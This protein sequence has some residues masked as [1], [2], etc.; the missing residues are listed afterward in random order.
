MSKAHLE[1]AESMALLGPNT[2]RARDLLDQVTDPELAGRVALCR[3]QVELF[4]GAQDQAVL[5]ALAA[6]EQLEDDPVWG[7][8]A[9]LQCARLLNRTLRRE[10]AAELLRE[11]EQDAAVADPDTR[12][13]WHATRGEVA[14]DDQRDADAHEAFRLARGLALDPHRAHE[15]LQA[16]WML[17]LQAQLRDD[18]PEALTLLSEVHR[19]AAAHDDTKRFG[20]VSVALGNLRFRVHDWRAARRYLEQG[21]A[22]RVDD[23][24]VVQAE[25][26]PPLLGLLARAT[27]ADGDAQ[28]AL[29]YALQSAQEGAAT[30][31][32]GAYADGALVA[33][34]AQQALGLLDDARET[35]RAAVQVLQERGQTELVALVQRPLD[36]LA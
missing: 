23:A 9:A 22:A 27:L 35:L 6:L 25:M 7:L 36:D 13:L 11:L 20:E 28:T 34:G 3:S 2:A 15:H 30:G 18:V 21:L 31:N 26:R 5:Y 32:A 33:S 29:T 17:G 12:L 19:I 4:G 24:P 1:Q 8:R 16:T 14:L 10:R